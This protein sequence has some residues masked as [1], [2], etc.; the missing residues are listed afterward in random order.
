MEAKAEVSS[1]PTTRGGNSRKGRVLKLALA[2]ASGSTLAA[3]ASVASADPL[4]GTWRVTRHGVNCITGAPGPFS[5]QAIMQFN[6]GESVVGSAVPPGSTLANNSPEFGSWKRDRGPH[7]YTFRLLTNA[8]DETSGAF[9][10]SA[11]ISGNLEL[12]KGDDS[13]TYTAVISNYDANGN[14]LF[15]FCGAATGTRFE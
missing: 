8:H 10:G 3:A 7:N 2:L 12:Q 15:S 9:E 11:V 5:F 13:F 14:L 4:E 1:I 6:K